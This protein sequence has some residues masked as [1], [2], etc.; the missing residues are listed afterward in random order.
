MKVLLVNPE[1][2]DTYWSFR[3]ALPFEG[4]R[5]VF[6]PLALLTVSSLL[7]PTCARRLVDLNIESLKDSELEWAD[8]VFITGMLAQKESLHEVVRR[9]KRLGKTVV[10]GGPY[11]TSTIEELPEADHIF[12]GEAETTLPQFFEDLKRG[13]A[14]RIYKAAARP[15]MSISPIPDFQ[16]ADLKRYSSMSVQYSRGCPFSCEFC[17]IIEIY[18]RVPRTKSNNQ[19]L[20]E[21]DQLKQRGWRGP[22]F[23]VDDNFIG[24]KK[25]VRQLMPALIEW[26]K[27]NGYPFSL[28][29]EASVNLADDDEL[30]SN[31][32]A[33]GFRRVFLGIE[34]PVEESLKEAQK[35]QNRGNLLDS[36]KK[37]Q[38]Y[39]MEVMAGFIVGFDNDPDD[40]FERQ[41]EFIRESAIPLAM[42]GMLNALPD[43]QLW[44]RLER[45]G[46]L[47][48][49]ASGNN[50]VSTVNFVPKMDLERL[51]N[52]YQTIMQTI[53]KPREY[54][55]RAL[56]SL[57]RTANKTPEPTP[58]SL[59]DEVKGLVR[60]V[61]KLGVIDGERR[62]FWRF[63]IQAL[64]KH[65]DR[66]TESLR[67][68]AMGYHFRKLNDSYDP[69][70]NEV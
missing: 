38:S 31:M 55:Q 56:D 43:T 52:G 49:E 17:D 39:G 60:L 48:G 12:Q 59:L 30:L 62:E 19:I 16:L 50:T 21:L 13:E 35:T 10:L 37:I 41:I 45:E 3:H 20:N 36:V 44:K 61:L 14:S 58:Y 23:I 68:A 54:Y 18:G 65:H 15:P 24:N 33:A 34:T 2:P 51:V 11:V 27:T 64:R 7:P 26:Q 5:C 46:R 53:Y 1:F 40:I 32:R 66:M 47:L 70:E 4:K 9:C 29:T 42:V 6:P 67:L 25:N 63:F 22:L 8:M 57:K 28:L 69:L